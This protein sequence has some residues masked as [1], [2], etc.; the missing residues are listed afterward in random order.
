MRRLLIV[1]LLALPL[2][3]ANFKLYLKDGDFH[4]VREYQVDGD[5]IRFYSIERS[6]W[7]EMPVSLIDLKRT[8]AEAAARKAETEKADKDLSD[9]QAAARET[10]A[11]IQKIPQDPGLYRL[12]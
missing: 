9:E 4:L 6:D 1:F 11:E 7:E 8:E 2:F 12:E 10:R 5:R 3:A